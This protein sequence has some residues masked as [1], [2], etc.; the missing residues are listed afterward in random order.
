MIL[1]CILTMLG[2]ATEAGAQEAF[3]HE[4]RLV[5]LGLE[6]PPV[7]T[8]IANYVRALRAGQRWSFQTKS[9]GMSAP[10]LQR[11]NERLWELA[12]SSPAAQAQSR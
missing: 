10:G 7:Y 1:L 9:F 8:P 2:R 6:L 4:A 12:G 5:E 3:D 11:C